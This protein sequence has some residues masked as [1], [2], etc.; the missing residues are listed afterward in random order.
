MAIKTIKA[1]GAVDVS[2][3]GRVVDVIKYKA[4]RNLSDTLDYSDYRDVECTDAVVYF[5]RR[6]PAGDEIPPKDR[7]GTVDCSNLF[8]WRG[9]DFIVPEVDANLEADSEM[10][11]D[12][13]AWTAIR[14]EERRQREQRAAELAAAEQARR[15]E[16]ERNRPTIG[17]RMRVCRGRKVPIG[18]VG[19]VAY[20]MNGRVLLKDDD[21]WQ[22]R[23][24]QGV[25]VDA[26]YLCAR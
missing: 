24:A 11:E 2:F 13:R 25:W 8:T 17:K 3:C 16:A 5:G 10:A 9:A 4:V 20:I 6:S 23:R 18:T 12:Y 26:R 7:F 1:S 22:D 19:T 14:D 15:A 21:K